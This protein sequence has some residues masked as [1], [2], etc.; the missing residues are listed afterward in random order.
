MG[1]RRC[2]FPFCECV[3]DLEYGR[4]SEVS[5]GVLVCCVVWRL[6]CTGL[7]GNYFNAYYITL[8]YIILITIF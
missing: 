4:N 7:T 2:E 1:V 3:Y 8:I 5:V 6:N